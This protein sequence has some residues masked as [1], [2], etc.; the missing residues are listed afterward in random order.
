V[1]LFSHVIPNG[2][3]P[4][5]RQSLSHVDP[6]IF[7]MTLFVDK[8]PGMEASHQTWGHDRHRNRYIAN[9]LYIRLTLTPTLLHFDVV[10]HIG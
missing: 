2:Y 1:I 10:P 6:I 8:A 4:P 5:Q 9:D 3:K 7:T